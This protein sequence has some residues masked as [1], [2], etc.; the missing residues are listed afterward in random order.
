ME[1]AVTIPFAEVLQAAMLENRNADVKRLHHGNG[2]RKRMICYAKR[3]LYTVKRI[4]NL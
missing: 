1:T 3:W 2:P 4:G